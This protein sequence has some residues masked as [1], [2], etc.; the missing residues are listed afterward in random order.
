VLDVSADLLV[1]RYAEAAVI[2]AIL[3]DPPSCAWVPVDLQAAHFG[4]AQCRVIY[5][6]LTATWLAKGEIDG[7]ILREALDRKGLIGDGP[8]QI[9]LA[10]LAKIVESMPIA[11][12]VAFYAA[13]V[14]DRALLREVVAALESMLAEVHSDKRAE[15]IVT[16]IQ[17]IAAGLGVQADLHVAD[18][19]GATQ[20][21]LDASAGESI[22]P[23]GFRGLDRLIGGYGY[24]DVVI[25]GGRPGAAKSALATCLALHA[26]TGGRRVIYSTLEMSCSLTWQ[27]A[28]AAQGNHDLY[29]IRRGHATQDQID[30]FHA[31]SV[32]LAESAKLTVVDGLTTPAQLSAFIAQVRQRGPVGMVIIDHV[33]LMRSGQAIRSRYEDQTEVSRALKQLALREQVILLEVSQLNRGVEARES[34]RPSLADLRDSGA[35][36]EDADQVWLLYREDYYHRNDPSWIRTNIADLDIAKQRNGPTGTVKLVFRAHSFAFEDE[37]NSDFEPEKGDS[38]WSDWSG[39]PE[40]VDPGANA[41]ADCGPDQAKRAENGQN[42]PTEA[43]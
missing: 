30:A 39:R 35:A 19:S 43:V 3:S 24:G 7:L 2:S 31:T 1:K 12:N 40:I 41:E 28:I 36:E 15:D 27:R 20:A 4:D 11:A 37:P 8:A 34:K 21:A 26:C 29:G 25:I 13:I 17:R 16:A 10:R 18:E 38:G 42:E 22:V 23:T 9:T 6:T 14:R 33:Q 5:E 32:S